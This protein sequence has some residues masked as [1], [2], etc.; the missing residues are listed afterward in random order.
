MRAQK[1]KSESCKTHA[2]RSINMRAHT[3]SPVSLRCR[4]VGAR[5][6]HAR[7]SLSP[8][9]MRTLFLSQV[10]IHTRH[11]ALGQRALSAHANQARVEYRLLFGAD[12]YAKTGVS[13]GNNNTQSNQSTFRKL[14][15]RDC[16]IMQFFVFSVCRRPF[17]L[18]F[19]GNFLMKCKIFCS[20]TCYS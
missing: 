12:R 14:C 5:S 13:V 11:L 9:R 15:V 7:T 4:E 16:A 3:L 8:S 2:D 20:I 1:G 19:Y 18:V 17:L 6:L 10:H